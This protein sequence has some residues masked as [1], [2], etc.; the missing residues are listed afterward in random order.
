[1]MPLFV[2]G[3][4]HSAWQN[5]PWRLSFRTIQGSWSS[6][7]PA[8]SL[9][10]KKNK[11]KK[12]R[13][14]PPCVFAKKTPPEEEL[15]YSSTK[16][17]PAGMVFTTSLG[18]FFLLHLKIFAK[19]K[20]YFISPKTLCLEKNKKKNKN[21]HFC[22][23]PPPIAVLLFVWPVQSSHPFWCP[24]CSFFPPKNKK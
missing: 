15:S 8:K 11:K 1:M 14:L 24:E 22:F 20:Q 2:P 6:E 18:F 23:L 17:F 9:K 3:K 7:T 21:F 12:R 4:Q 13:K 16:K 10:N 19:K 5:C